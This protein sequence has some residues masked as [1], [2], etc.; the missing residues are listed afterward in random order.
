MVTGGQLLA[1]LVVGAFMNSKEWVMFLS[2]VLEVWKGKA[3]CGVPCVLEFK[4]DEM[5]DSY[6]LAIVMYVYI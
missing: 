4:I 3:S 1:N 5:F 2:K 6:V